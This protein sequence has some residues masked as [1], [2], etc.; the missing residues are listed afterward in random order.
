MGFFVFFCAVA[1][2]LWGVFLITGYLTYI[3]RHSNRSTRK[4]NKV[5]LCCVMGSGGHTTEMINLLKEMN[6]AYS[7]RIYVIAETDQMSQ[8]KVIE[9]EQ[10]L[11]AGEFDIVR[12]PRSR[13]VGQD[14]FS[15]VFTTINA[16]YYAGFAVWKANP[17]LLLLNGPGTCIP[18]ALAAAILD[19]LRLRDTKIIYEESI[20]RV[21]KLS[22]SASIL[23][24]SG[25]ADNVIV[26][27]PQL[28]HLYPR[29]TYIGDMASESAT[30]T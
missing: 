19:M 12:I 21:E 5:R 3:V 28:K 30:S 26:Q 1:F 29:T 16:F 2:I 4:L 9:H 10:D 13:E 14:Y 8:Q 24:Y 15:S 18:V 25:L 11:G 6:D 27:W 22:M 7:P 20:C 23:Y 17:D